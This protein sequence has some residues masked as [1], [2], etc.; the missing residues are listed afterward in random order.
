MSQQTS[1]AQECI[2][3]CDITFDFEVSEELVNLSSMQGLAK[4]SGFIQ[5]S[6]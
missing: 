1:T 2:F 5:T 6:K 3:A 4:A